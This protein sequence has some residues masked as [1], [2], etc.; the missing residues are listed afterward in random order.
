M[1][2]SLASELYAALYAALLGLLLSLLWDAFSVVRILFGLFDAPH[3]PERLLSFRFPFL[4]APLLE[5]QVKKSKHMRSAALFLLDFLYAVTAGVSFVLFLYAFYDGVFRL[6]LL[7]AAALSFALYRLSLGRLVFLALG[8]VAFLLRVLL[9]YLALA[10]KL[11]VA[12]V[13]RTLLY[14]LRTLGY[15]FLRLLLRVVAPA[16]ARLSLSSARR[17]SDAFLSACTK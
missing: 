6:F 4:A 15:L 9:S 8:T 3:L 17:G 10:V 13:G 12:I 7:A 16:L 5:G 1:T 11:P 14:A 2:V